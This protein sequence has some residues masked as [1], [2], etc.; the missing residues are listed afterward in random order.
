MV[1]HNAERFGLSQLHQLRGR[2]GRSDIKSYCFLT[3]DSKTD[4]V[5]ERLSIFIKNNDGFSISE[6]DYK[7]RGAGDFIGNRQSGKNMTDLGYLK[8][9]KESIFIAKKISDDLFSSGKIGDK[10]IQMAKNKYQKLKDI[11]LN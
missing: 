1:I 4:E 3:T 5:M 8:Y 7:I 6:E 10:I 11:S 2:V 9:S